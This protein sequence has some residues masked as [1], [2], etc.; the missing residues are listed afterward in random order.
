MDPVD[1]SRS[2]RFVLGWFGIDRCWVTVR[3]S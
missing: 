3:V 2:T 1:P